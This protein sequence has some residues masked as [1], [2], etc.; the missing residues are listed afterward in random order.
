MVLPTLLFLHMNFSK[1]LEY[2]EYYYP[3]T[4][5]LK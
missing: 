4:I 3:Y 5:T 2:V 1:L